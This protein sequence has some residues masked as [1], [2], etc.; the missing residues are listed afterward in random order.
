MPHLE[1]RSDQ[2][3][4]EIV[5]KPVFTAIPD[6]VRS[7]S[8]ASKFWARVDRT[9]DCWEWQGSRTA[10][11][12]GQLKLPRSTTNIRA[13]RLA[14]FLATGRDPQEK[15]VCHTC[16]NPPC[17]NPAHLFLGD[18][19]DNV[20]DMVAKGRARGGKGSGET[21]SRAKMTEA[22]ARL[23]ISA[24]IAG[25]TNREIARDLPVS[26]GLISRIRH[27]HAWRELATEMGYLTPIRLN[28]AGRV[29][30]SGERGTTL[31]GK[32]AVKWKIAA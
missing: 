31:A 10:R 4:A 21:N 19:A 32:T 27:R 15:L 9:K 6:A 25:K 22:E 1:A 5:G 26:H 8:Y 13:H 28:T 7:E 11:G 2:Q 24:I 29:V 30:D 17:C 23:V 18:D 14:Y 16:D 12:Y 20:Q 3:K